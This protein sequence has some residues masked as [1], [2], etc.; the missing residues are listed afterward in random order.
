MEQRNLQDNK[1]FSFPFLFIVIYYYYN[2]N[3]TLLPSSLFILPLQG[4]ETLDS[5]HF[6]TAENIERLKQAKEADRVQVPNFENKHAFTMPCY[7]LIKTQI[8]L[9]HT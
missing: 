4:V 3:T 1:L 2:F 5:S 6:I 8:L 7:F 9:K